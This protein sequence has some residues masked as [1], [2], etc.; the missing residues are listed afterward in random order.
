MAKYVLAVNSY[1]DASNQRFQ[2]IRMNTRLRPP[3]FYLLVLYGNNLS[4]RVTLL[5]L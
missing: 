1:L 4:L 3:C 5:T 2:L